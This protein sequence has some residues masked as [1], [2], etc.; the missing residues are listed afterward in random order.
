MSNPIGEKASSGGEKKALAAESLTL[1]D[2][3]EALAAKRTVFAMESL[4]LEEKSKALMVE[5]ITLAMKL[6]LMIK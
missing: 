1:G 2:K 4:I 5:R 6:K 3:S